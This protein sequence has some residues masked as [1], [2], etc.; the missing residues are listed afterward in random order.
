MKHAY[1]TVLY[2]AVTADCFFRVDRAQEH[3]HFVTDISS[4]NDLYILDP[5]LQ[6][7]RTNAK[8][9]NDITAMSKYT[10]LTHSSTDQGQL[11]NN[12]NLSD[13]NSGFDAWHQRKNHSASLEYVFCMYI[14]CAHKGSLFHDII[15]HNCNFESNKVICYARYALLLYIA[16]IL[17]L[18]CLMK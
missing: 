8:T 16:Q 3:L 18:Y 5:E 11:S 15:Y 13:S 7:S 10:R 14:V 1:F 6:V 17:P 9:D 4:S 2:L 12:C